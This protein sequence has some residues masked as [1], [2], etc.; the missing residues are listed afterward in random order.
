MLFRF[1]HFAPQIGCIFRIWFLQ[2]PADMWAESDN[3]DA[4]SLTGGLEQNQNTYKRQGLLNPELPFSSC[5]LISL[6]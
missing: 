2:H 5:L 3:K 6:L 4:Q 1:S